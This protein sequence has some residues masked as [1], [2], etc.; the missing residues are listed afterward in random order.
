MWGFKVKSVCTNE[1][2]GILM[3]VGKKL[4]FVM[5]MKDL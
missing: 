1:I 3:K 4:Y 2:L 5:R